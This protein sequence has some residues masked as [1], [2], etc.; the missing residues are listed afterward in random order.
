MYVYVYACMFV[1]FV[2]VMYFHFRS[3]DACV[4]LS[5]FSLSFGL[6][7][8]RSRSCRRKKKNSQLGA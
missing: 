5:K 3:N 1:C 6:F 2:L 8:S 4:V 7:W